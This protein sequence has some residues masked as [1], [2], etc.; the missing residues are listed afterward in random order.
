MHLDPSLV[1]ASVLVL[2]VACQ[3]LAWRARL[4]AILPLLAWAVEAYGWRVSVLGGA[5]AAL[6]IL[7]LVALFMRARPEDVG[8]RPYGA[9]EDWQPPPRSTGTPISEL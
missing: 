1:I 2:G 8:A 4:P 6:L 3:W 5:G 7:P 9:G